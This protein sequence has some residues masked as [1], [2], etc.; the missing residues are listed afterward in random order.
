[1]FVGNATVETEDRG[2]EYGA[3]QPGRAAYSVA[4]KGCFSICE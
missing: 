1:M 4:T 2:Y 3:V